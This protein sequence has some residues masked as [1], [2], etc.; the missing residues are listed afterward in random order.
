[1][2]IMYSLAF[3]IWLTVS[4]CAMTVLW[5]YESTPGPNAHAPDQWPST[6]KLAS[7]DSSKQLLVWLHPRCPCSRAT[8]AQLDRL[9]VHLPQD[10]HC[11]VIITQPPDV[12]SSFV[13]TDLT[14]SVRSMPVAV[15]MDDRQ[16]E[17]RRFGVATSGQ[18]L[19]Y[20]TGGRL[21]F[22]GGITAGRGHHGDSAGSLTLRRLLSIAD[23]PPSSD[24]SSVYGCCLFASDAN[25]GS[26]Q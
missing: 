3:A 21:E 9:L 18:V 22:A 19:L 5:T 13:E 15:V 1:M 20:G 25:A 24:S 23:P 7:S 6:S 10:V 14:R 26:N 4:L 11:Q 16:R 2:R 8:V 17:A 12:A